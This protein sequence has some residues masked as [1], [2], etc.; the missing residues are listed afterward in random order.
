MLSMNRIRCGSFCM[1]DRAR[2]DA[3]AE[4]AH[5]AHQRA[6]GDAGRREDDARAGREIL[7]SVDLLEVGDAHRPAALLVLGLGD[8]EP[9]EDLAVQAPHRGRREHAFRRAA[10]AHHR[11]D[12]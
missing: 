9:R 5:A 1:I 3:V 2:A 11:V 4:E 8:D 12:A 7:R 6:V 10:G